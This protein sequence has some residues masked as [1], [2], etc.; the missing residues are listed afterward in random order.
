MIDVVEIV[1]LCV[2]VLGVVT[3]VAFE[4][5]RGLNNYDDE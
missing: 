4:A 3:Y 2:F 1:G 5:Q